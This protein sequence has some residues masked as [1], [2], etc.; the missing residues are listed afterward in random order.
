MI[1]LIQNKNYIN[2]NMNCTIL[3]IYVDQNLLKIPLNYLILN[4]IILKR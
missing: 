4:H 1:T 2:F 3:S